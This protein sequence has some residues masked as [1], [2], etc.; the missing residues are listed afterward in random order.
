VTIRFGTDGW[1]AII[2]DEFT[3]DAVRAVAGALAG[4]LWDE[5]HAG[6]PSVVIG[7]DRRFGSDEFARIAAESLTSYG[8]DV[9]FA[10]APITT[11]ALSYTTLESKSDAG[12]MI[13]A[14]HN[15]AIYNGLK[16]K[17]STGGAAPWSMLTAIETKLQQAEA[18]RAHEFGQITEIDPLPAYLDRIGRHV[19]LGRI[20][21]AGLTIVVDSM[22]GCASGI[23]PRVASGDST[24][25]VE[26]NTVHN[27]L[28]PGISSP[29][30]IERNLTRLKKVV[31]DGGATIGIAFDGDGDRIG[32]V[33]EHGE[34]VSSQHV[35]ALLTQY[36]LQH[37][38]RPGPIV[39]SITSTA[40][41]DALAKQAS[42]HLVEAPTG[43]TSISSMMQAEGASI[44]GEESGGFAFG[45]HLPD[46]D[47]LLAALLLIDF[48]LHTGLTISEL[49][50]ELE[51]ATGVWRSRRIDLPLG[52]ERQIEVAER[53]SEGRW[54]K[55]IG[56]IPIDEVSDYDGIRLRLA[57]GSWLLLRPSGTEPLI[58]LYAEAHDV[59]TVDALLLTA[60]TLI[61]V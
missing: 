49:V 19:D 40:M 36:V 50:A 17:S 25:I 44:G 27:P 56:S 46:R 29:E 28:F 4:T 47:G 12:L 31:G 32:V 23:M 52:P 10:R 16:L 9:L 11:P 48:T 41:I 5:S 53:L 35:F 42:V 59:E 54:P 3:F 39:K 34:Y 60:R 15:P 14:S 24:Q 30:P 20:R 21:D 45:F 43:F 37:Q 58:R 13:T 55:E 2:A 51:N 61:G 26:L 7:F 6:R 33:N 57:D 1:R 22:Y 38:G 18:E 8:I